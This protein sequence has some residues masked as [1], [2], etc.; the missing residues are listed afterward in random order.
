MPLPVTPNRSAPSPR[1]ERLDRREGRALIP[2][3]ARRGWDR[4]EPRERIPQAL[5]VVDAHQLAP[6]QGPQDRRTEAELAGHMPGK[7]AAAEPFERLVEPPL[8]G[9]A[10]EQRVALEQRRRVAGERHHPLGEG[11]GLG[12]RRLDPKGHGAHTRQAVEYVPQRPLERAGRQRHRGLT[13]SA[14]EPLE[15]L[16]RQPTRCPR[17]AHQGSDDLRFAP[18]ASG[19]HAP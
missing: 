16:A 12:V 1:S 3:E 4:G 14:L 10:P 5:G 17:A 19:Q 2:R 7:R 13:I 15:H 11:A 6:L 9:G 18:H 8:L